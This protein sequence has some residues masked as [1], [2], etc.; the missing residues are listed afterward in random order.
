MDL[1]TDVVS[2]QAGDSQCFKF[3]SI[4]D[5]A[6]DCPLVGARF[7][8]NPVHSVKFIT[9]VLRNAISDF[10]KSPIITSLMFILHDWK[11]AQ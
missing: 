10:S 8:D 5:D 3:H 4:H 9:K 1:V 2:G 7:C 11:K 6:F